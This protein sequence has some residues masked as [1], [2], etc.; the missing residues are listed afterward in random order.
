MF[1]ASSSPVG[2]S[3]SEP[4]HRAATSLGSFLTPHLL[5]PRANV[6]APGFDV[7]PR[8][9]DAGR[10]SAAFS[11]PTPNVGV[12]KSNVP[13]PKPNVGSPRSNVPPRRPRLGVRIPRN[14]D[15]R[16]SASWTPVPRQPGQSERS[17]AG[18]LRDISGISQG[19]L[20][21]YLRDRPRFTPVRWVPLRV[22]P[23]PH[24]G[25]SRLQLSGAASATGICS[26]ASILRQA[27]R[28]LAYRSR[29]V[30]RPHLTKKLDNVGFACH[31]QWKEAA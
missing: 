4:Q 27:D 17:D 24:T 28:H 5:T 8:V 3:G 30:K 7:W 12:P 11:P 6:E 29:P 25:P 26:D 22:L 14:L 16:S 1:P 13:P 21:G 20:R 15:T 9:P 18:Y 2:E 10:P 23:H 31:Q 19:Y